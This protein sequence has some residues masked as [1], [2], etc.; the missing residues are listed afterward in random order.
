M[1]P[2]KSRFGPPSHRRPKDHPRSPEINHYLHFVTMVGRHTPPSAVQ[3]CDPF[4]RFWPACLFWPDRRRWPTAGFSSSPTSRT[5]MGSTSAWPGASA[6]ALMPPSPIANRVVSRRPRPTAGSMPT[7]SPARSRRTTKIVAVRAAANTS[8]L[9]AN[10]ESHDPGFAF[11]RSYWPRRRLTH[12]E[13]EGTPASLGYYGGFGF[14][15]RASCSRDGEGRCQIHR[16][17]A[18]ETT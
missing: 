12:A 5:A 7:K 4:Q 6:A 11:R 3:R 15:L 1:S 13:G 17:I 14:D 8:P 16:T 9:P 18:V 10:A 2:Q